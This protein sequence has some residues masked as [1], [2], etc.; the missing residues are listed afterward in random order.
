MNHHP[1]CIHQS[2]AVPSQMPCP[3]SDWRKADDALSRVRRVI[4]LLDERVDL[5]KRA[6]DP[7]QEAYWEGRNAGEMAGTQQAADALRIALG[8]E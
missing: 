3:C 7:S 2:G 5:L 8:D 4:R 6:G 1:D